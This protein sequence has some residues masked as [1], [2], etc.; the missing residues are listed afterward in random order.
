M[1]KIFFTAMLPVLAIAM[2]ALKPIIADP[3][4]IGSSIPNA[5]IKMKDIG[6]NEVS[7]K[8]AMKK[9]GLLVMFSCNTC[10]VVHKYEARTVEICKKALENNIGVILLNPNEAN[11]EKVIGVKEV[12]AA[13]SP[14]KEVVDKYNILEELPLNR[15]EVLNTYLYAWLI[16]PL[17]MAAPFIAMWIFVKLFSGFIKNKEWMLWVF[18]VWILA[19]FGFVMIYA[20]TLFHKSRGAKN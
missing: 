6:G 12:I 11:R 4:T 18:T 19:S 7:F 2:L 17:A 15:K 16:H 20:S 5:D 10:P 3:I 8:D 9:N 13:L 1:K 14:H